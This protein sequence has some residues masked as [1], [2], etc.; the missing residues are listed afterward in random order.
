MSVCVYMHGVRS[1][2]VT[3]GMPTHTYY[4]LIHTHK[5]L[6]NTYKRH[7]FRVGTVDLDWQSVPS[8]VGAGRR[9]GAQYLADT[10]QEGSLVSFGRS[11]SMV[12]HKDSMKASNR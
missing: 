3:Q 8:E 2:E 9:D 4:H 7:V 6:I 5:H 1:S 10:L 11:E 12:M